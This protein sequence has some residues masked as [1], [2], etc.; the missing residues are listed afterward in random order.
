MTR[1]NDRN[2]VIS[3]LGPACYAKRNSF[4]LIA[5]YPKLGE[6]KSLFAPDNMRKVTYLPY[7]KRALST[8]RF[9]HSTAN[10]NL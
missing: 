4:P 8:R 6:E 9:F 1:D 10:P 2:R 3:G 7:N 5:I